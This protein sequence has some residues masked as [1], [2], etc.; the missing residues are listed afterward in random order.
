MLTL[1]THQYDFHHI[2]LSASLFGGTEHISGLTSC[3]S[4]LTQPL[5][6]RRIYKTHQLRHNYPFGLLRLS[7]ALQPKELEQT[8][9]SQRMSITAHLMNQFQ[10]WGE[11]SKA[12]FFFY[13]EPPLHKATNQP[14]SVQDST[15]HI[16]LIAYNSC[17][18]VMLRLIK[19]GDL[20]P[21]DDSFF[22]FKQRVS[23][24]SEQRASSNSV[25]Q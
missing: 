13:S 15:S 2:L 4:I 19:R 20:L 22:N 16:F 23:F 12:R 8:V 5:V 1:T 21:T 7:R 18:N 3:S 14:C 24:G 11:K 9:K 6:I 17:I 10:R 25:E